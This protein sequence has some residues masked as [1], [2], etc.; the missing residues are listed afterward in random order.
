[1]LARSRTGPATVS[2]RAG[3][4]F[5]DSPLRLTEE[6]SGSTYQAYQSEIVTLSGGKMLTGLSW[7]H[8][9][10][11]YT[12]VKSPTN[13]VLES[14]SLHIYNNT[15]CTRNPYLKIPGQIEK[16]CL[17]PHNTIVRNCSGKFLFYDKCIGPRNIE[18]LRFLCKYWHPMSRLS[19]SAPHNVLLFAVVLLVLRHM[20]E[21]S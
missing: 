2:I 12:V 5:L 1:M 13:R 16:V 6:D 10:P 7:N 15:A 8:H 18:G 3:T 20:Y 17:I 21:R 11:K 19:K 9:V 4:Y 14:C